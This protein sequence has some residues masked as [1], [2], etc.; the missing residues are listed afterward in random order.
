[1]NG[2]WLGRRTIRT[3]W[4]TRKPTGTGAGDGQYGRT[5]LNYDDVYNQ[6]GPDNTSVY[7][8]NVNSNANGRLLKVLCTWMLV[9]LRVTVYW[10]EKHLLRAYLCCYCNGPSWC[11]YEAL[12][13]G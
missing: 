4:A 6:T 1:M 2:Q 7:V 9:V 11:I 5:E 13:H 10:I 3:N 12:S 8:G